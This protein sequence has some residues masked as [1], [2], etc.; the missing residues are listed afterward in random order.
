MKRTLAL[1]LLLLVAPLARA[2]KTITQFGP[3]TSPGVSPAIYS[4]ASPVEDSSG[5]WSFQV[6]IVGDARGHLEQSNDNGST[7]AGIT[8]PL[9]SSRVLAVPVC[10]AC[11]L[12]VRVT[13]CP[14]GSSM[15]VYITVSGV[16]VPVTP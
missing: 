8:P 11:K 3:Y 2:D 5:A 13:N 14:A 15:T 9:V 10:G 1:A 7:W 16:T 12:R 4:A 6:V